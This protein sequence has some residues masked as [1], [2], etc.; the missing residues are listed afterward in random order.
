MNGKFELIRK[1]CS[2]ISTVLY[3][4]ISALAPVCLAVALL[5]YVPR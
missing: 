3:A 1:E 5:R 4:L 2:M